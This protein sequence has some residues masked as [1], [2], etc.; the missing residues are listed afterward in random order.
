MCLGR[1]R[2]K[3]PQVPYLLMI[4]QWRRRYQNAVLPATRR[5]IDR[6]WNRWIDWCKLAAEAKL[7][8]DPFRP[9]LDSYCTFIDYFLTL[10]RPDTVRKYVRN[11]NTASVERT[12]HRMNAH[13]HPLVIKRTFRAAARRLGHIAPQKRLPLT[14]DILLKL[15]AAFDL[16]LHDDRT[17]WAILCVG[18]FALA[19]IGEL[20]PGHGS[21][22]KV[23]L[24]A[25]KMVG[26]KGVLHLVG[27]KTDV[28]RKGTDLLFFRNNSKCCPFT[29]MKAYLAARPSGSS[30]SPLFVDGMGNKISQ[31]WVVKRLRN[32]L[33]QI[34]LEAKHFCGISLRKGGAQ[35]LLRLKANDTIVMGMG[36][37][38]SSCF[39][40]YLKVEEQDVKRWQAM[41]VNV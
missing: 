12:G 37:W 7:P 17:L 24:G 1:R 15:R 8:I 9:P 23:T 28:E 5:A 25:V 13:I 30:S 4:K 20:V 10:F 31:T 40:R 6:D 39:N 36:R 11:I 3:R 21:K 41:M 22:L 29:A 33:S 32:K 18:V 14:V 16:A 26:D 38:T 27:T 19:R 2:Y 34:G 35:T